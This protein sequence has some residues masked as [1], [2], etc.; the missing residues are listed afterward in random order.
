M[1]AVN[2]CYVWSAWTAG[3]LAG[4]FDYAVALLTM[5]AASLAALALL[6]ALVR[7]GGRGGPAAGAT[8]R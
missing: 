5:A 7:R 4:R 2:L 1:G 3:Q 6:P 8:V